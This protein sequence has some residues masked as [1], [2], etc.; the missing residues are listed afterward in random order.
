MS[1]QFFKD[2]RPFTKRKR[3]EGPNAAGAGRSGSG[4]GRSFGERGGR[5]GSR[6]S[7]RGGRG[8]RGSSRGDR[9]SSRGARGGGRGGRGA[10][11]V[12]SGNSKRRAQEME[13]EELDEPGAG[14][15]GFDSDE[16]LGEDAEEEEEDSSE[17]EDDVNETPAQKRLRLSQMYLKTLEKDTSRGLFFVSRSQCETS[18][19]ASLLL[20]VE[21][22]G[23]NA[24]DLDRDLIA[25]RLQ[26]DVVRSIS[27]QKLQ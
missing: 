21:D 3:E 23:F 7:D 8:S 1:D 5:G 27:L 19:D 24:A 17:E 25:E 13:D 12:E 20:C 14:G 16:A 10:P 2:P 26:Q 11:V 15:G 9:G 6:G 4:S 22:I 18:A